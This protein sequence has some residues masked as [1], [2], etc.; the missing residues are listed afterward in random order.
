MSL[1]MVYA[2]KKANPKRYYDVRDVQTYLFGRRHMPSSLV[3][4]IR[5]L[6]PELYEGVLPAKPLPQDRLAVAAFIS[7]SHIPK[8]VKEAIDRLIPDL[9]KALQRDLWD[10]N[11]DLPDTEN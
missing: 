1:G 10:E 8:E 11:Q 6:I 9:H 3:S 7:Q 4:A 2:P 5:R